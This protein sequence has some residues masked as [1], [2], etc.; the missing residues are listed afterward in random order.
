M[1]TRQT[2]EWHF[3]LLPLL[4]V[5]LT[6][7]VTLVIVWPLGFRAQET[8]WRSLTK[9][10][11]QRRGIPAHQTG[12]ARYYI[13]N[14]DRQ[15]ALRRALYKDMN[16]GSPSVQASYE[17]YRAEIGWD[18]PVFETVAQTLWKRG[19]K[20]AACAV[21]HDALY[22][23]PSWKCSFTRSPKRWESYAAYCAAAGE[24][25]EAM[26]ARDTAQRLRDGTLPIPVDQREAQAE[27]TYQANPL[28]RAQR[29]REARGRQTQQEA[30]RRV[31]ER[32]KAAKAALEAQEAREAQ[33]TR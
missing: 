4:F 21:Y 33:A 14:S 2:H 13:G 15:N 32:S 23:P 22:P 6:L 16:T 27:A 8:S 7:A 19:E 26:I 12:Y 11:F 28:V 20:T 5:M 29:E 17:R 3:S 18:G 1:Q 30:A 9:E 25:R 10:E 24:T 31:A